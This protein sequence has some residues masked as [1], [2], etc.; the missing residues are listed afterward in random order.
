[1]KNEITHG[2]K[3]KK[4]TFNKS[5]VSPSMASVGS[6]PRASSVEKMALIFAWMIWKACLSMRSLNSDKGSDQERK[7]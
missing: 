7:P 6:F 5:L 3:A 1:M 2:K 4:K